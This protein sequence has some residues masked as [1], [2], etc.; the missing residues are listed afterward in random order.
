MFRRINRRLSR[1]RSVPTGR[2]GAEPSAGLSAE[3]EAVPDVE[4][5]KQREREREKE[6]TLVE[7]LVR[8]PRLQQLAGRHELLGQADFRL[9]ESAAESG[10]AGDHLRAIVATARRTAKLESLLLAL[11]RVHSDDIGTGWFEL[12]FKL[13]TGELD[14]QY[15]D[16]ML[17]LIR[18][19]QAEPPEFGQYAVQRYIFDRRKARRPVDDAGNLPQLLEKLCDARVA[20]TASGAPAGQLGD[21]LRVLA[22]E[23]MG[24]G[25]TDLLAPVRD[26]GRDAD[27]DDDTERQVIIQIRVEEEGAPR[28]VPYTR[29]RYSLRGYY[30]E[31]V[32][33]GRPVFLGTE[34]LAEQFTG[35]E[36][37][38]HV[39]RFLTAWQG[40][41]DA[42]RGLT[43]RMEFLLPHSLLG[44]PAEACPGGSAG[45]PL[46]LTCQVVVRSLTRYKDPMI[47]DAWLRRW[48]A[49]DQGCTPGDAL[50]R[51]GWM[52]PGARGGDAGGDKIGGEPWH[53]PDGRYPPLRLTD[54]A[55]VVD[56]L[57]KHA[58]LSCLGLAV[59]Y[60]HDDDLMRDAVRAALLEDGIPVMVWRRDE[61]DPGPMLDVLKDCQPPL[62]LADLPDSVYEARK[63]GRAD[64]HGVH[65]QITLLWDDPTCVF[66]GQ[67]QPMGGTRGADEGAA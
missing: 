15:R 23:P 54:P 20:T 49:L 41:A 28:D 66:S 47:H 46:S 17:H 12:A 51:I 6:R 31:R 65:N 4:G 38:R 2:T 26:Q 50:D 57:A 32:G 36:L 7:I 43:K 21:F 19:V 44:H 63:R 16:F 14:S 10:Q 13:L 18:E 22:K 60:D 25:L 24:P 34:A 53:G 55:D 9:A 61:G 39:R 52:G 42:G 67:D 35:G 37:A 33:D 45:V 1:G 59:P 8:I 3:P 27:P 40:P 56:W 58:D 5:E 11:K 30:Y 62:L 48:A 29:R 64:P